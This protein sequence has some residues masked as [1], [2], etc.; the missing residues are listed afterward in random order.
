MNFIINK[1]L[2]KNIRDSLSRFLCVHCNAGKMIIRMEATLPGFGTV[3]FDDRCIA[4]ILS[5]PKAKNYYRVMYD[6]S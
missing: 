1:K 6:I 3:L 4:N 5:L 2:V